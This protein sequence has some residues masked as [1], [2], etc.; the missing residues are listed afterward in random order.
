MKARLEKGHTFRLHYPP[1][2][3]EWFVDGRVAL[4]FV[5]PRMRSSV[6]SLDVL[7]APLTIFFLL[8]LFLPRFLLHTPHLHLNL[9]LLL[10]LHPLLIKL[11]HHNHNHNHKHKHPL[12]FLTLI[13]LPFQKIKKEQ[14]NQKSIM[15]LY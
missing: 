13:R 5:F 6:Q 14:G 9:H 2:R 1:I 11:N 3:K 4:N 7:S 12:E 15:K 8:P 10:Y